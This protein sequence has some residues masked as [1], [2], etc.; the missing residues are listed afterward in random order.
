MMMLSIG[1]LG[2]DVQTKDVYQFTMS[3]ASH[4]NVNLMDF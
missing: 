4:A 3:R 2:V 1:L